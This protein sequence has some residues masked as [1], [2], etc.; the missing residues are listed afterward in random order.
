MIIKLPIKLI[1]KNCNHLDTIKEAKHI[2]LDNKNKQVFIDEQIFSCKKCKS[3]STILLENEK[4]KI[5]FNV[6]GKNR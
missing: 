3:T 2:S 5:K 6:L 4:S 1:C